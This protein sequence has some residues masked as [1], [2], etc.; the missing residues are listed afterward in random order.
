MMKTMKPLRTTAFCIAL[1][2]VQSCLFENDMSYPRVYANVTAFAVE[3]QEACTINT[4]ARTVDLVLEE[5]AYMNAL[6][7]TQSEIS[8]EARCPDFPSVGDVLDLTGP[9][10]YVLSTYQDYEWTISASQPIERYITCE[11]QGSSPIIDAQEKTA[12]VNVVETQSLQSVTVTSMKLEREGSDIYLVT[13][14][15]V[16]SDPCEFPMTIDAMT[17][18]EFEVR[19]D[20]ETVRWKV[21]FIQ[22]VV[23]VEITSV[24]A[25]CYHVDV[26]ATFGRVGTPYIEYRRADSN[27]WIRFDDVTVDGIDI[28]ASIPGGDTSDESSARLEAGTAYEFKVCTESSESDVVTVTTGTPDQIYNMDFEDWYYETENGN[29]VWYPNLNSSYLIWDTANPGAG[30]FVG[31]LTTPSETV[32]VSSA[33]RYAAR[34]ESKNAL[35]A[36]AAG[37]IF[38]GKFGRIY[39]MGAIL[40][41]G[42]EFTAR[43]KALT[44]YFSYSPVLINRVKPPYENL[45]NT[46]DKCQILV[47]LTDWSIPFEVNT[48]DGVFVVQDPSNTSIIAY[49]KMETDLETSTSEEAD[50]NGYIPFTLELEYWRPDATPTYAV[51]IACSSYRGDY[52]TGGEGSVMLVDDFR[53]IYD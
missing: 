49:G 2:A 33:G 35:I 15:T 32:P 6:T 38:T 53:F 9:R 23:P 29:D 48:T 7:V 19:N 47:M 1:L 44:G 27:E 24:N 16:A 51:V 50:A 42:T 18:L 36:F 22:E 13:D 17:E 25:W 20:R 5:T 3:G 52:F 21:T 8:A 39:G 43:P 4:D 40:N 30:T 11:N 46:M 34:L 45:Q 10:K 41:W 37:N 31:S 14:G 28:S 26:T 12:L